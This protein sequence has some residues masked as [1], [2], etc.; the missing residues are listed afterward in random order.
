MSITGIVAATR[1]FANPPASLAS[2]R[3]FIS[4]LDAGSLMT[5]G[6]LAM[7]SSGSTSGKAAPFLLLTIPSLILVVL[8]PAIIS[9]IM[10]VRV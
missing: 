3:E 2:R 8:A 5:F 7:R 9:M 4:T 10:D 1:M 6:I